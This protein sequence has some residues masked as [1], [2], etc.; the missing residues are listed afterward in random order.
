MLNHI[1]LIIQSPNVIGFIRDFKTYT[2][3]QF[4]QNIQSTEPRVLSLFVKDEKY[5]FWQ[6]TN[7]PECIE[8][9][10]FYEQ[11][12]QYIEQNPVRKQYVNFPENWVYSSANLDHLLELSN[13][14]EEY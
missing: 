11:K 7:M 12:K 4:K 3:K 14:Y 9:A 13:I 6:S 10:K 2:S 1:H 8:S 5:Q